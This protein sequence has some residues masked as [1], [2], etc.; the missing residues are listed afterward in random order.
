VLLQQISQA[1]QMRK[2]WLRMGLLQSAADYERKLEAMVEVAEIVLCG[3]VGGFDVEGGQ[4][5]ELGRHKNP[6]ILDRAK[7]ILKQE[8][9]LL[10]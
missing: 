2:Q 5:D 1:V 4:C 7:H 8:H 6:S 3:S 10:K 9:R